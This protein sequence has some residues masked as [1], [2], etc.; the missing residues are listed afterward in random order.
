MQ[1]TELLVVLASYSSHCALKVNYKMRFKV[2]VK[3]V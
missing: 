1:L 3:T 2:V